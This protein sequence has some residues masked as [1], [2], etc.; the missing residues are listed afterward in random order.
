MRQLQDPRPDI[1]L[2]YN[3]HINHVLKKLGYSDHAIFSFDEQSGDSCFKV[4]YPIEKQIEK[5]EEVNTELRK[6]AFELEIIN[7]TD[8]LGDLSQLPEP[9]S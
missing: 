8:D 9:V 5:I 7:L 1:H 3:P 2:Y 6:H 4:W